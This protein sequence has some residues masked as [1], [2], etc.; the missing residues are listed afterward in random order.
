[1]LER[2]SLPNCA[3]V[4]V[5]K[6]LFW[7]KKLASVC[8]DTRNPILRVTRGSRADWPSSAPPDASVRT[9]L[10]LRQR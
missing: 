1:M 6:L 4:R 10:L 7:L 8:K 9:E 5:A 3:R 2:T